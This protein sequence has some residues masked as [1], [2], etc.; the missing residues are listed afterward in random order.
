MNK[1]YLNIIP[2]GILAMIPAH[3]RPVFIFISTLEADLKN[4]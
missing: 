2:Q 1:N 3:T 4:T